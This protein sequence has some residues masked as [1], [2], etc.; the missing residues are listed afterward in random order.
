MGA[1]NSTSS[2]VKNINNQLYMSKSTF[3]SLNSQMN[4]VIASTITKSAMQSGGTIINTQVINFKNIHASGDVEIGNINQ[5][6]QAAFTFSALNN[7]TA[8]NDAATQFI[9]QTLNTIN[10]TVSRDIQTTMDTNANNSVKSGFLDQLPLSANKSTSDVINEQNI[11]SLTTT[12]R[13]I[14]NIL[15]NRVQN[16]FTT[17]TITNCIAG[18]NNSQVFNVTDISSATGNIRVLN[19]TQSQAATA[20]ANCKGITD[21]TNRILTE[22]LGLMDVK[23]DESDQIDNTYNANTDT[24]N[25]VESKGIFQS[26]GDLIGSISGI[27]SIGLFSSIIMFLIVCLLLYGIYRM[28]KYTKNNTLTLVKTL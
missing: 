28:L 12:N 9:Q 1:N 8:R 13:N 17:D 18:I 11:K 4:S 10:N 7:T 16:N 26:L 5:N 22:T 24:T 23:L 20:I 21:A 2:S 14:S 25:T 6:Q 27:F 19:I 3:N 15:Q